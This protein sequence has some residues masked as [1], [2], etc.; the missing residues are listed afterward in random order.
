MRTVIYEYLEC[1]AA[2]YGIVIYVAGCSKNCSNSPS[3][4]LDIIV[5]RWAVADNQWADGVRFRVYGLVILEAGHR[6][7]GI[8]VYGA[9]FLEN[10]DGERSYIRYQNSKSYVLNLYGLTF[11]GLGR[12]R[13]DTS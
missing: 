2:A 10:E 6:L 8:T 1:R 3:S 7:Y 12:T 11:Y 13:M 4:S 9:R 5:G